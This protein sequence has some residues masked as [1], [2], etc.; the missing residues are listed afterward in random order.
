M[1]TQPKEDLKRSLGFWSAISIVVGTIIGS[2]IFFKQG[3]VLDSAGTSTLA[4][5]AWVFGGVITLTGGLTVAEMVRKCPT[6]VACMSTSKT[7]TAGC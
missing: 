3:S 6:P 1:N 2:G 7:F 5:A 4:I